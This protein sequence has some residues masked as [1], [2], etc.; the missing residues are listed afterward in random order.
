[1]QWALM[2]ITTSFFPRK[3]KKKNKI[4][5]PMLTSKSSN[6]TRT[7][8]QRGFDLLYTGSAAKNFLLFKMLFENHAKFLTSVKK[9]L[10]EIINVGPSIKFCLS[11]RLD[12]MQGRA[13]KWCQ[14][15]C[16]KFNSVQMQGLNLHVCRHS[17]QPQVHAGGELHT[18]GHPVMIYTPLVQVSHRNCSASL[19]Q[20]EQFLWWQGRYNLGSLTL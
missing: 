12:L 15:A 19:P 2:F 10:V 13:A 4:S 9:M 11:Y 14:S 5:L 8:M 16:G 6:T 1:M 17:P 18:V 20:T 3:K 7:K